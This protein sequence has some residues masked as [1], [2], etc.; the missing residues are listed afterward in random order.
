MI[1]RRSFLVAA[2]ALMG[3][4]R[5]SIFG[6]TRE[7]DTTEGLPIA[8]QS[9]F[10]DMDS[11]A[12]IGKKYLQTVPEEQ[13]IAILVERILAAMPE[14][15]ETSTSLAAVLRDKPEVVKH[16]HQQDFVEERII[17][18][19]GWL[20]SATEARLCALCALT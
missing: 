17:Q 10:D 15:Q 13:S 5:L 3:T 18:V 9:F 19:D 2:L 8:L 1:K 11:A 14:A 6:I 12:F 4:W 16:C 7:V 20:L